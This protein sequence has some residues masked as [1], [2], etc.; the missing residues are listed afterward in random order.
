MVRGHIGVRVGGR[1]GD[2]DLRILHRSLQSAII[3]I[4]IDA[5]PAAIRQRQVW[6]PKKKCRL[7]ACRARKLD[8]RMLGPQDGLPIRLMIGV[9]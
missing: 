8:L 5:A 7:F 4:I 6:L 2:R 9:L 3:P 1:I